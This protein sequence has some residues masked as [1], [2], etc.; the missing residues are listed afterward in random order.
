M[1]T[2]WVSCEGENPAD[3]ENIGPVEYFPK[4]GFPGYFYPYENSEGYLSPLV[5]V[6]FA[7]PR[8]KFDF[9][10]NDIFNNKAC[11]GYTQYVQL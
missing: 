7:S 5:A 11:Q 4:W 1:N 10:I 8:S 9:F 6:H 2:I 3:I